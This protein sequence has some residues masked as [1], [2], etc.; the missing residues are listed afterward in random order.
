MSNVHI[1]LQNKNTIFVNKRRN[2]LKF[3]LSQE[4]LTPIVAK[5]IKIIHIAVM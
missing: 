4:I 3:T 5:R 1:F 2:H